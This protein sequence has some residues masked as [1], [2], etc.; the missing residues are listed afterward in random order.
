MTSS[1]GSQEDIR[2]LWLKDFLS[3]S[4]DMIFIKDLNLV[5]VA[6]SK[7]VAEMAGVQSVDDIIGKT[8]FEIFED[9]AL[10]ARYVAVDKKL[11]AGGKDL[12]PYTE[13]IASRDGRQRFTSTTKHILR[14]KSGNPVG[15]YGISRDITAL[16]EAEHV[17]NFAQE[18]E[19]RYT[20]ALEKSRI[21]VWDYDYATKSI[22]QSP[23]SVE[24]HGFAEVIP[25]V[26]EALIDM[27]YLHPDYAASFLEMYKELAD[28]AKNAEGIFLVCDPRGRGWWYEHIRYTNLFDK[29]GRP[30][31]AIG[32]STDV[33]ENFRTRLSYER[34]LELQMV[35]APDTCFTLLI[36]ITAWKV[37]RAQFR[38]ASMR[39][40]FE[41]SSAEEY[42]RAATEGV[43]DDEK[44]RG[45]FQTLTQESLTEA[46]KD[47]KH[48]FSFEYERL[49]APDDP[50]WVLEEGR[51]TL[52]PL[53]GNLL[54]F[55][56]IKDIDA[57]RRRIAELAE[58]AEA[59][60]MTGLL[61]H[62]ATLEH[63]RRF[64][65]NGGGSG[66][67]ALYIVDIDNF[68]SVNDKLGHVTGDTAIIKIASAIRGVFRQSDIIGRIGG[69]EFMILLKNAEDLRLVK[70]KGTMLL[71]ALQFAATGVNENVQITAS[72]GI[73]MY[74]GDGISL[75]TL[76]SEADAAL[77]YAKNSGKNCYSIFN[78]PVDNLEAAKLQSPSERAQTVQYLTLLENMDAGV[79]IFEITDEI[80][81]TYISPGTYKLMGTSAPALGI[82]GG[83]FFEG[84]CPED[85]SELRST[86]FAAVKEEA[87]L[88]MAFRSSDGQCDEG[89]RRWFHI[90]GAKLPEGTGTNRMLAVITEIS[91]FKR[92]EEQLHTTEVKYRKA[93][94]QSNIMIWELDL[95]TRRLT[96]SGAIAARLGIDNVVF[97]NAPESLIK[98][99]N[100]PENIALPLRR[101][102]EN[103]YAGNEAGYY[104]FIAKDIN[105]NELPM[106]VRFELLRDENGSPYS[107]VG[108]AEP[109]FMGQNELALYHTLVEGGVFSALADDSFTLLY[110]ND[111]FFALYGITK[112]AMFAEKGRSYAAN[113][114]KEDLARVRGTVQKAI[115]ADKPSVNI[116]MRIVTAEGRLK[117]T[118]VFA[119]FV[120]LD[121]GDVV[122]NGV[123][124]DVTERELALQALRTERFK[125]DVALENA[126]I[127]I[128]EYNI[129]TRRLTKQ[130][131]TDK[132][133]R[134][135][136][137]TVEN[138]PEAIIAQGIVASES[139][140]EYRRL[141]QEILDGEKVSTA[142]IHFLNF[143][144][145]DTWLRCTFHTLFDGEG[146]PASAI[147][148]ARDISEIAASR[149]KYADILSER[150]AVDKDSVGSF[151]F[152]LTK[153]ICS[154]GFGQNDQILRLGATGTVDGF[155]EYGYTQNAN[156][157]LLEKFKKIFN[158]TN[159][160][161]AFERGE[162]N[163]S[164]E[165][166]YMVAPRRRE[167]IRTS[168]SMTRNPE[169]GDIEGLI[170]AKNIEEE[171]RSQAIVDRIVSLDYELFGL[172]DTA[173]GIMSN[174]HTNGTDGEF[175]P[176]NG[177]TIDAQAQITARHL[178][179]PARADEF[180]KAMNFT[181]ILEEV[182]NY[183]SCSMVFPFMTE[184]GSLS[185]RRWRFVWFDEQ[186]N[187]LAYTR[188]NVTD[189]YLTERDELT[190]LYN[191]KSFVRKAA[192][193]LRRNPPGS[194]LLI[195]MDIDNFKV[196][197]DRYGHAEGDRL[198]C[199]IATDLREKIG[200]I[201]GGL[202]CH[203][204]ADTFLILYPSDLSKLEGTAAERD[205]PY[206]NYDAP[207]RVQMRYGLYLILD[208]EMDVSLM[209]DRAMLA[210]RT[211]KGNATCHYAFYTEKM[212]ENI[213]LEQ[214]MTGEMYEALEK[215]QFKVWFQPQINYDT[216]QLVGAEALVRWEHPTRGTIA[217]ASFIPLF[218]RNGFIIRLDEYVWEESC[219]YIKKWLDD[220]NQASINLS[221]NIS[222]VDMR[223]PMIVEKLT[224]LIDKYE[225]SPSMLNLEIT[226]SSYMDNPQQLVKMVEKM[227]KAGFKVEMDDF[228]A[229][230]SSLNTLKDVP[231]D[232]LKLD[233]RFLAHGEDD[234]RGGN[235]LSSVIR[236]AHWLE[237][238]VVAEGVETKEQAD[239]LKSLNC[240]YMQ[241]YY[242]AK[243]MSAEL[244]EQYME[245]RGMGKPDHYTNADLQGVSE[246]WN[247]SIQTSLIFNSLVGGAAICEYH[248]GNLELLRANDNFFRELCIDRAG[249]I[250]HAGH[251]LDDCD[252]ENR[253]IFVA[254]LEKA[255]ETES[256]AECTIINHV[257]GSDDNLKRHIR[258]RA[259]LLAKNGA[260]RLFYIAVENFTERV[261]ME[262]RLRESNHEIETAM[263]NM[264]KI[265]C[266]YE[267][268][269]KTLHVPLPYAK[270]HGIPETL[271]NFPN[272]GIDV[273][274]PEDR[275]E[276]LNFYRRLQNGESG[277]SGEFHIKNADGSYAWERGQVECI[278]DKNNK[279]V[280]AVI[281]IDD[282][283]DKKKTEIESARN[284]LL[285]TQSELCIFDYDILL[286]T[287]Y[288]EYCL[289][290]VG[291]IERKI[292]DYYNYLTETEFLTPE[293]RDQIRGLIRLL[294]QNG[295]T[296]TED[297][298]SDSWVTGKGWNRITYRTLANDDGK[299]YRVVGQVRSIQKEKEREQLIATLND[300]LNMKGVRAF[301][302]V[303]VERAFQLL[304]DSND[305]EASVNSLLAVLGEHFR[306]P[307]VFITELTGDRKASRTIFEWC[308]EGQLPA[309]EASQ[310]IPLEKSDGGREYPRFFNEEGIF[311]CSDCTQLSE[312][313]ASVM[314]SFRVKAML[315]CS[316]QRAGLY[317]GAIAMT[318][319]ARIREWTEEEIGTLSLIGR[320]ISIFLIKTRK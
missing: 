71:E 164:F 73:T 265:I 129:K 263:S 189:E 36:D 273:V 57:Q 149:R 142:D 176:T 58:A 158:R 77:Y 186:R 65:N 307:H 211:V 29:E 216:G 217:P 99:C 215:G 136:V 25:G 86:L 227:R 139:L 270:L 206:T 264:G 191:R 17:K 124:L 175:N 16:V 69:D 160:I 5:Y 72:I 248:N 306:V 31:R 9:Q 251:C 67:H 102:F 144:G 68:K 62:N 105:G 43:V 18:V 104:N 30:Y 310:N 116:D 291:L 141:Y 101:L 173:T 41:C 24:A 161:E 255:E 184:D 222:R 235:I 319:Y 39:D 95:R 185:Y 140:A 203:D 103:L 320:M 1:D 313:L 120:K 8:D 276:F 106:C 297:F 311:S 19:M 88:D 280:R 127:Y 132:K 157:E 108:I 301:D 98:E 245:R 224:A 122:I 256:E 171:K 133:L 70:R 243:P 281:S 85:A 33:T 93:V 252:E 241:G 305:T 148:V 40:L 223:D 303:L 84:L 163:L 317:N 21:S 10:A 152:N 271:E 121:D 268:A 219:R 15:L 76:C 50:R 238:P 130:W 294:K 200:G 80:K 207:F 123:I 52:D 168:I 315:Q 48:S 267:L 226:E 258:N 272:D 125:L 90:K 192:E 74:H 283:G 51:Y 128:W 244:F 83:D 282:I 45:Y 79:L 75:E 94:E 11:L 32:M 277:Y 13:P 180:L 89:V 179:T 20:I 82:N 135:N 26:P 229:G 35:M 260:S 295:G 63:L 159:L 183:D 119:E 115:A 292:P 37:V 314:K 150:S 166:I 289:P 182:N 100:L 232:I 134:E 284:Q 181:H 213:L 193:L 117:Y 155:F 269:T 49:F 47:G 4:T 114:F 318:E 59:D 204:M 55:F 286:D 253:K 221:V 205:L 220:T 78:E 12:P 167:W 309:A 46:Y 199:Y 22:I 201:A 254:M 169:T 188:T 162:T 259:R 154:E 60:T 110:G 66:T 257:L 208:P 237:I 293:S 54:I 6:A 28:G 242:F 316:V 147:G 34:D 118:Q 126:K 195:S 197:N 64:L 250:S 177:I 178:I 109:V 198:L 151:W 210:Q 113:I 236:M 146:H 107:A 145:A 298:Q 214:E 196:L 308:G 187:Y 233:M 285:V 212:R 274:L 14:D 131:T 170:Y 38:D 61:N 92:A 262:E 247:P 112:E 299:F 87:S 23:N 190:G 246:F 42:L 275:S 3:D 27:G 302:S 266:R 249:Y 304:Y 53:T 228:G 96:Q 156:N 172:V 231:V 300:R 239:F 138:A 2:S 174:L 81:I 91:S 137:Y 261:I 279:A 209:I 194:F 290:E 225:L 296:G 234:A 153:N 288:F 218:E 44:V 312:P 240:I 230:Y 97:E 165:H 143:E 7:S 111:R 56:G 287:L 278:Y 202:V